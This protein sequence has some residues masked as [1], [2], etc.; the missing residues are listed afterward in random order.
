V[1]DMSW[2]N[3][4]QNPAIPIRARSCIGATRPGRK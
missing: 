4:A 2:D 1:M 3:S